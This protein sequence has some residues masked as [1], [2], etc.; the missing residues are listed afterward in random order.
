M[1]QHS[2][3]SGDA[4]QQEATACT[5][6]VPE[7]LQLSIEN[8]Y[9]SINEVHQ[10]ALSIGE[11]FEALLFAGLETVSYQDA[12]KRYITAL[13]VVANPD[14]TRRSQKDAMSLLQA[15]LGVPGADGSNF[16]ELV[17][18]IRQEAEG[19]YPTHKKGLN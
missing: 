16:G 17:K 2:A 5:L 7:Y 12:D 3:L 4:P 8:A 13:C 9:E 15:C 19:I 6:V 1:I 10:D 18:V 14:W 11:F